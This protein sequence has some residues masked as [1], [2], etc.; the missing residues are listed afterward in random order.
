MLQCRC[1]AHLWREAVSTRILG[2]RTCFL[3]L[4]LLL[5]ASRMVLPKDPSTDLLE[6]VMLEHELP[7]PG[8]RDVPAA[9]LVLRDN[10]DKKHTL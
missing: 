5:T 9:T 4:S 2:R 8:L 7:V 6:I 1:F 3:H 10:S